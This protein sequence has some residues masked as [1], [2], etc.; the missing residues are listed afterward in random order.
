MSPESDPILAALDFLCNARWEAFQPHRSKAVQ[1]YQ[2]LHRFV[3]SE[4]KP[5][6]QKYHAPPLAPNSSNHSGFSESVS[7]HHVPLVPSSSTRVSPLPPNRSEFPPSSSQ[8]SPNHFDPPHDPLRP[9]PKLSS[10]NALL[11]DLEK[12]K[13][14]ITQYLSQRSSVAVGKN[15]WSRQDSRLVDLQMGESQRSSSILFRKLLS[16]RSLAKEYEDWELR[17]HRTSR[18]TLVA[19][20]LSESQNRKAGYLQEYSRL[21]FENQKCVK[22]GI[23]AGIKLLAFERWVEKSGLS[24]ILAFSFNRFFQLKYEDWIGLKK[25][26]QETKWV[27]DLAETSSPWLNKCQTYYDKTLPWTTTGSITQNN[28]QF[29]SASE[30]KKKRPRTG[31]ND[32][33]GVLLPQSKDTRTSTVSQEPSMLLEKQPHGTAQTDTTAR[34]TANS[35]E[36]TESSQTQTHESVAAR[37]GADLNISDHGTSSTDQGP[38]TASAPGYCSI[39]SPRI[40]SQSN[41]HGNPSTLNDVARASGTTWSATNSHPEVGRAK[42]RR[43]DPD[44]NSWQDTDTV[45]LNAGLQGLLAAVE[46]EREHSQ[47]GHGGRNAHGQINVTNGSMTDTSSTTIPS[48]LSTDEFYSSHGNP[49]SIPPNRIDPGSIAPE[50]QPSLQTMPAPYLSHEVNSHGRDGPQTTSEISMVTALSSIPRPEYTHGPV[51]SSTAVLGRDIHPSPESLAKR[52]RASP[53]RADQLSDATP[54]YSVASIPDSSNTAIGFGDGLQPNGTSAAQLPQQDQLQEESPTQSAST[55]IVQHVNVST[56]G[57]EGRYKLIEPVLAQ[58]YDISN[59]TPTDFVNNGPDARSENP[60]PHYPFDKGQPVMQNAHTVPGVSLE[61]NSHIEATC[62]PVAP[63]VS[64]DANTQQVVRD[65]M[66]DQGNINGIRTSP[67]QIQSLNWFHES[68]INAQNP[69][70]VFS[71]QWIYDNSLNTFS[72]QWTFDNSL[73]TFSDQQTSDNPL[74]SFSESWNYVPGGYHS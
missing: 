11:L 30:P 10:V 3:E 56:T 33:S 4:S 52:I 47:I 16:R 25:R 2:K 15:A 54:Y 35:H 45:R 29:S 1:V 28:M 34:Q 72:D 23:K 64:L 63:P 66:Q 22:G 67:D 12:A 19:T 43:L 68:W 38:K 44:V 49:S 59:G 60:D 21:R 36:H 70:N 50:V 39:S 71:D 20:S 13:P 6:S 27:W 26:L 69:L 31:Q 17:T 62:G 9:R 65:F 40:P 7:N 8:A 41:S 61:A 48:A 55:N 18:I 37:A 58:A 74:N 24:A 73:N 42:R 14:H 53:S 32:I 46:L 5:L 57:L 51:E